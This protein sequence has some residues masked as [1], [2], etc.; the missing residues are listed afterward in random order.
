MF[1][2]KLPELYLAIAFSSSASRAWGKSNHVRFF[3][4]NNFWALRNEN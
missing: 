3:Q 1:G 4:P 2:D